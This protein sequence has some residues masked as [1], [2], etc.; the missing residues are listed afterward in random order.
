[1]L[2]R[3]RPTDLILRPGGEGGAQTPARS[4]GGR[5]AT[6]GTAKRVKIRQTTAGWKKI[7]QTPAST[8]GR[9]SAK[10]LPFGVGPSTRGGL[11]GGGS[12][13]K[14]SLGLPRGTLV[15]RDRIAPRPPSPAGPTGEVR[16]G[17]APTWVTRA[18]TTP[19]TSSPRTW[20]TRAGNVFAGGKLILHLL[21]VLAAQKCRNN[22]EARGREEDEPESDQEDQWTHVAVLA[23]GAQHNCA[24]LLLGGRISEG[25]ALENL[26]MSMRVCAGDFQIFFGLHFF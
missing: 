19:E 20:V 1:M 25:D 18:R 7:R 9:R 16:A 3:N 15:G 17:A 5:T 12:A 4:T 21:A 8:G 24:K 11:V 14:E 13:T 26:S 6:G 2:G 22:Q 23:A 10:R